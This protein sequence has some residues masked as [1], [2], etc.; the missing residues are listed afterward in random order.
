MTNHSAGK[1]ACE[2]CVQ[3]SREGSSIYLDH[4]PYFPRIH[5]ELLKGYGVPVAVLEE[6]FFRFIDYLSVCSNC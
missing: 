3:F 1:V 6:C 5:C 4:A 2:F